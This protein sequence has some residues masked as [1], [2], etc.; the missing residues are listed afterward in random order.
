MKAL[1]SETGFSVERI[2]PDAAGREEMWF[3]GR[4]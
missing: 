4:A 1:L 3:V 2:E